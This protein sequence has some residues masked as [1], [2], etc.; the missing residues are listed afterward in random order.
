MMQYNFIHL[1]KHQKVEKSEK[2]SE[3]LLDA[4]LYNDYFAKQEE[5]KINSKLAFRLKSGNFSQPEL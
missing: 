3:T 5:T 1:C 4:V 2:K